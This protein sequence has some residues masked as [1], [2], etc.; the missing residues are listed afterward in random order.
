MIPLKDENPSTTVPII[1]ILLI[2]TNGCIFVYQIYFASRDAQDLFLRL[3][4]IPFEV[5][6]FVDIS[7][8]NLVPIPFTIL[9]AM[10]IH[11]G[12]LHLLSNMLYLWIFGDN[13]EDRLGH[14]KYLFFYVMCGM[15]ASVV[16]GFMDINSK[17]PSVGASGAI[18]GV[19]AAYLYLFPGARIKTLFVVFVFVKIIKLP[20][21]IVLGLWIL[22]QILSGFAEY[23]S[24]TGGGIAW[25][26]HIGGF[27][28]GLVLIAVMRKRNRGHYSRKRAQ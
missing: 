20:A 27:V 6:H 10:F 1:N 28:S 17:V 16:H 22:A 8:E 14:G 7:P 25:F 13:V 2:I 26:A 9:T 23:G 11:G 19:L 18:A 3:G 4:F 12:W 15:M 5:S 24:Q 21:L